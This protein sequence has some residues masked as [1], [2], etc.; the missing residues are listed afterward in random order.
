[1]G[2]DSNHAP[3]HQEKRLR[4]EVS[5]DLLNSKQLEFAIPYLTL[6]AL[7]CFARKHG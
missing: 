6:Q 5:F 3:A 2:V 7:N 1:M 4:K